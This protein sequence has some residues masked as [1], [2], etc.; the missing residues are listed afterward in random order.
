MPCDL[1]GAVASVLWLG[2]YLCSACAVEHVGDTPAIEEAHRQEL[3]DFVF[4]G[5]A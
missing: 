5:A 3:T 4:G 1:C 2:A